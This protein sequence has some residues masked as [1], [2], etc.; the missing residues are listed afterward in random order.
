MSTRTKK[1][2]SWRHNIACHGSQTSFVLKQRCRLNIEQGNNGN[3]VAGNNKANAQD[4]SSEVQNN[5]QQNPSSTVANH[6]FLGYSSATPDQ[7]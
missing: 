1:K 5:Y 4:Y 3:S 2:L 7:H 6:P